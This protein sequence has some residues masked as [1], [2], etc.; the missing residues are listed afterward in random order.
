MGWLVKYQVIST[1][2]ANFTELVISRWVKIMRRSTIVRNFLIQIFK[3]SYVRFIFSNFV[4]T[5]REQNREEE[6]AQSKNLAKEMKRKIVSS[7]FYDEKDP[8]IVFL[9]SFLELD[10]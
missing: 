10:E 5:F 8:D 1:M 9:K 4:E 2:K 7:S 6:I 3:G